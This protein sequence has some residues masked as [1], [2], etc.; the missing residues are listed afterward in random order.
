MNRS[1]GARIVIVTLAVHMFCAPGVR[2]PIF[3]Q[4]NAGSSWLVPNAT[5]AGVWKTEGAN[6]A[7]DADSPQITLGYMG[8]DGNVVLFPEE[9]KLAVRYVF[10]P[11]GAPNH[12]E[13]NV[14]TTLTGDGFRW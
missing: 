11:I 9:G 5:Y 14:I 3:A 13:T 7:L 12:G 6:S 4:D 2:S 10:N 1:L 8:A